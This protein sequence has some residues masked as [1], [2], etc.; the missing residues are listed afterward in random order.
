MLES[1]RSSSFDSFPRSWTYQAVDVMEGLEMV[2]ALRLVPGKWNG[3]VKVMAVGIFLI[4]SHDDG[5]G[6]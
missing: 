1:V 5:T 2:Q 6:V 4:Q 3:W